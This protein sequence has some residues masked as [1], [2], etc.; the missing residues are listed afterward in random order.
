[1]IQS[2]EDLYIK[3]L[4]IK[5]RGWIKTFKSGYNGSGYTFETL[6][7]I[8]E[9]FSE[10]PDFEG[11]EIKTQKKNGTGKIT[12]LNINP[13]AQNGD[14]IDIILNKIGYPDKDFPEHNVFNVSIYANEIKKC[15]DY[16][17]SI[18]VNDRMKRVELCIQN[19]EKK[20]LDLNIYWPYSLI[21]ERLYKKLTYLA[22]INYEEKEEEAKYIKFD[23]IHIYK[24]KTFYHFKKLLKNGKIRISFKIGLHKC[25]ELFGQTYNRGIGF[26]IFNNDLNDLYKKIL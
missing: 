10:M 24:F 12:L 18:N 15:G 26:D 21:Q 13:K 17:L 20:E 22:V 19:Y 7:G 1:M 3:F 2:I 16:Y 11:I 4:E 25:G 9:N 5:D 6:L 14:P 8:K 23:Q